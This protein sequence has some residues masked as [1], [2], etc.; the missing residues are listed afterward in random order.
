[1][2]PV[3]FLILRGVGH[4]DFLII[5]DLESMTWLIGGNF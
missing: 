3:T 1:M 4:Y 5:F 2:K